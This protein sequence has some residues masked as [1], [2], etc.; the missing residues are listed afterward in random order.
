MSA[1]PKKKPDFAAKARETLMER[2]QGLVAAQSVDDIGGGTLMRTYET[3]MVPCDK[4]IPGKYQKRIQVDLDRVGEIAESIREASLGTPI[5]VNRLPDGMFELI[6][7]EHR[8]RACRDILE[9]EEIP[10]TVRTLTPLE[11]EV[12]GFVANA[13]RLG[14]TDFE[15]GCA[16]HDMM[17]RSVIGTLK[18]ASEM[19]GYSTSH[20][21]RT[22][23]LAKLPDSLK[24]RLTE[25]PGALGGHGGEVLARMAEANL[26][27]AEEALDL[28]ISGKLSQSGL[29]A[30]WKARQRNQAID[31]P[32]KKN[33]T[34]KGIQAHF[35]RHANGSV[36]LTLSAKASSNASKARSIEAILDKLETWLSEEEGVAEAEN[37]DGSQSES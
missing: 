4:I 34:I 13:N 32:I 9:W 28:V 7:G 15:F 26:A 36:R 6:E 10:A 35:H 14:Y 5:L 18:E 16:V 12:M 37:K 3:R 31:A 8:L 29:D 17:A 23:I 19:S 21:H 22:L 30:W 24:A 1:A 33:Y 20:I 11:C 2:R 27:L 25:H